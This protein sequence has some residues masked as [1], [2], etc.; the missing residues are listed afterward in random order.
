MVFSF[1]AICMKA[2]I[3]WHRAEEKNMTYITHKKV[4]FFSQ[5]DNPEKLK[6]IASET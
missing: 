3:T 4:F 2:Y 5:S 1:I 6:S